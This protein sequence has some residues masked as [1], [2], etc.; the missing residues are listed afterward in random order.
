MSKAKPYIP[1]NN[2]DFHHF[3]EKIDTD[4]TANA[5]AWGVPASQVSLLNDW[6]TG[7]QPVFNAI[8]NEE[9]RTKQQ[10]L[11]HK[12]YKKNYVKFLRPF[13]QSFLTNNLSIPID[14]RKA[15]G[16]NPRGINPPAKRPAITTAPVSE[17]KPLGGGKVRFRFKVSQSNRVGKHPDSNG[18]EIFYKLVASGGSQPVPPPQPPTPPA[19]PAPPIVPITPEGNSS[20]QASNSSANSG[21]P[22]QDGYQTYFSTRASFTKQL[23]LSDIGKTLYVYAQ[24]VNTSNPSNS[25]QFSMVTVLVVS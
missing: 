20:N 24:W 8:V 14:E 3:E 25:G 13:C 12:T 17:I 15:M 6:S 9:T 23:P 1:S 21:L 4:V 5:A 10:V 19:P 7:Y 2:D 11:A 22:T 18:V 16:L